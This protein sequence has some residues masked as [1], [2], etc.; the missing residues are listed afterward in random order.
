MDQG[1][2]YGPKCDVWSLGV[3]FFMML[4][5]EVK[6]FLEATATVT[7]SF[8]RVSLQKNSTHKAEGVGSSW[9]AK[10]ETETYGY[11]VQ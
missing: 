11:I 1:K 5:G 2:G 9:H 6:Q 3:V 7:H 8:T 4:T 10:F